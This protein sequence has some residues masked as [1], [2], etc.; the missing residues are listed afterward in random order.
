MDY[1]RLYSTISLAGI[2]ICVMN[3]Q[4]AILVGVTWLVLFSG[5]ALVAGIVQS[6]ED[7]TKRLHQI[8]LL[9]LILFYLFCILKNK[10]YIQDGWMPDSWY[11]YSYFVL[12][13][14]TASMLTTMKYNST[15]DPDWLAM[16][17]LLETC[18]L[19]FV[20]IQYIIC[21]FFR[22]DGFRI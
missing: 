22:T 11:L 17:Y 6:P 15:N 8:G 13:F 14:I 2:I 16:T 1:E 10:Q 12:G 9:L 20:L 18:L 5:G 3:I 19:V 7:W 21:T 4:K